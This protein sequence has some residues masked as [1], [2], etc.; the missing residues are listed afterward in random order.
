MLH[1]A[2]GRGSVL[3]WL[4]DEIQGQWAILWG[5]FLMDDALYS[6]AFWIHTKTAEPIEMP[7]RI[8]LGWAL[9]TMCY[10]GIRSPEGKGQFLGKQRP[11]VK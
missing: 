6:I 7:F 11:I 5:F 9:G 1:I 8:W 10:M 2:Y 3:L 4:G